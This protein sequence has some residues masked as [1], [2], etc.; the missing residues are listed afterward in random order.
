LVATRDGI[1][2]RAEAAA[3]TAYRHLGDDI[4]AARLNAGLSQRAAGQAAGFSHTQMSRVER[5]AMPRASLLT[6]A[7]ACASVGLALH[8]RTYPSGDPVRDRAQLALISRLRAR[9][10]AVGRWTTEAPL[11]IPGDP[12]AFDAVL[13]LPGGRVAFEAETRLADLQATE[14][15][16][17][18][19]QRDGRVAVLVLVVADT[20]HNRAVLTV[21]RED[22]RSAFPLDARGVLEPLRAGSLPPRNG[23]VLV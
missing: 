22:L 11:A 5:G 16:A 18:L 8:V 4:R 1:R 17:L 14:R 12:R 21:H 10:P 6:L 3:R 19:K 2:D 20:R 13:T 7:S 23:L 15:R 9:L